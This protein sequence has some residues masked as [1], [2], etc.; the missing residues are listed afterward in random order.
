MATIKRLSSKG[1]IKNIINYVLS[2]EKTNERI[3]SGKDCS[4]LNAATEMNT[5]KELYGKTEGITYNHIIQSFKPGEIT[6]EKAHKIGLELVEKQFKNHEVLIATHKDKEHIHN[7]LIINSV[8]FKDGHK[9]I[10]DKNSLREIKLENNR[11]CE[12]EHLSTIEKPYAR[13]RYAMA[14]YKLAERGLPIWKEQLRSAIDEAKEHSKNL[15]EIKGYLKANFDIEMKIQNKN[16][17]YLHPDKQK[18]CRGDKLGGAYTKEGVSSEFEKIKEPIVKDLQKTDTKMPDVRSYF[19]P[20]KTHSFNG[21]ISGIERITQK[22]AK[23]IE[24]ETIR[25]QKKNIPKFIPKER[26]KQKS[27]ERER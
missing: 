17:S 1:S 25:A 3:V 9:L 4:P 16:V 5:T 24:K 22:I 21:I 7:H 18:Y 15:V 27:F 14:E 2:K 6:P 8:S 23:D 19:Y 13:N 10:T 12:R 11:I 26:Q 20:D